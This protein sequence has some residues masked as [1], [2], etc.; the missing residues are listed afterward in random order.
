MGSQFTRGAKKKKK[1]V[2]FPTLHVLENEE[3][4]LKVT[5][6]GTQARK[7]YVDLSWSNFTLSFSPFMFLLTYFNSFIEV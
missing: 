2:L 5:V 6:R 3:A 1:P 4:K 7:I